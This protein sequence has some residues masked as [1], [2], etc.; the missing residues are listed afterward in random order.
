MQPM[1]YATSQPAAYP[2]PHMFYPA[3][4]TY[5]VMASAPVPQ[6]LR[7]QAHNTNHPE[8]N[9]AQMT[10]VEEIRDSLREFRD[11]VRAFSQDRA[12]RW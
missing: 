2:A 9:G 3:P 7:T 4:Q 1:V 8:P 11:A 12:N 5:P 6:D 10:P